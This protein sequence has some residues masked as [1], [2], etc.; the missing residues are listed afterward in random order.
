MQKNDTVQAAAKR[1]THAAC[2]ST[3]LL[4]DT[5]MHY[6]TPLQRHAQSS[7]KTA[8]HG[9]TKLQQTGLYATSET[10]KRVPNKHSCSTLANGGIR[11]SSHQ[12]RQLQVHN[13]TLCCS[14]QTQSVHST[15]DGQSLLSVHL[16]TFANSLSARHDISCKQQDTCPQQDCHMHAPAL[17]YR[18]L[19]A[20]HYHNTTTVCDS[21]AHLC[22]LTVPQ[23][24]TPLV[25]MCVLKGTALHCC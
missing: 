1:D 8:S 24:W 13:I 6:D 18:T 11:I 7:L 20:L 5:S 2:G 22:L 14:C 25:S 21:N 17:P 10:C 16:E 4:N 9:S 19:T 3:F 23:N 12:R 15:N